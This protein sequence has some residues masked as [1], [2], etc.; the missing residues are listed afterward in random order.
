MSAWFVDQGL[1]LLED[2]DE[3]GKR[4]VRDYPFFAVEALLADGTK[5]P[6]GLLRSRY[7]PY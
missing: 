7:S 2:R 5:R 1:R 6:Y 3:F 4:D